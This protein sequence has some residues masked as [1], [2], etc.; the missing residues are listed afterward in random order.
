MP[1]TITRRRILASGLTA[2][3]SALGVS[4]A[5]TWAPGPKDNLQRDLTP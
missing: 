3:G 4:I 2:A 1:Q 5:H